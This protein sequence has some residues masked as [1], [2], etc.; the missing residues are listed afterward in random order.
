[1]TTATAWCLSKKDVNPII[2]LSSIE[3]IDQAMEN[4]VFASEGGLTE[5]R[6]VPN[7]RQGH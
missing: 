5:E 7:V 1:M 4:V 3:W 2:G 6:Y